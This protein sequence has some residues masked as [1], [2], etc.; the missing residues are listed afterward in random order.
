[1]HAEGSDVAVLMLAPLLLLLTQDPYLL[2]MIDERRRYFPPCAAAVLYLAA[3]ALWGAVTTAGDV[4][5]IDTAR[6]AAGVLCTLPNHALF[7]VYL[8]N[9]RRQSEWPLLVFTPLNAFPA[10]FAEYH[11][12]V[13]WLA[14]LAVAAAVVQGYSM[15]QVRRAGTRLI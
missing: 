11:P 15:R 4:A 7:A 13:V 6:A 14:G 12:A 5:A 8:W 3:S 9:H 1:M 10:F 2:P